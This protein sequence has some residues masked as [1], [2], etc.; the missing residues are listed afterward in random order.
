MVEVT[1]V[2]VVPVNALLNSSLGLIK[3][4]LGQHVNGKLEN[5][6]IVH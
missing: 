4:F 2:F 3:N 6:L 1:F 5:G